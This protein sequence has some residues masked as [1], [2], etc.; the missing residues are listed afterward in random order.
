MADAQIAGIGVAVAGFAR[1]NGTPQGLHPVNQLPENAPNHHVVSLGIEAGHKGAH[2]AAGGHAANAARRIQHQGLCAA[3]GS[4]NGST[5]TGRPGA[6]HHHIYIA[7]NGQ[8]LL[9]MNRHQKTSCF[10]GRRDPEEP[11][12]RNWFVNYFLLS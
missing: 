5:Q 8:L 2:A 9:K 3:A 10:C 4:G 12:L 1:L 11:R 6:H 7:E